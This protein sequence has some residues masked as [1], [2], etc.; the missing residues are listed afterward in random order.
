MRTAR[1]I[2]GWIPSTPEVRGADVLD[3]LKRHAAVAI[4][5][6]APWNGA[7]PLLDRS[8]Q[9]IAER[10]K[11]R[12][13]FYYCNVDLAENHELCQQCGLANVPTLA[14]WVSGDL[15]RLIVGCRES[16]QLAVEIESQLA[17]QSKPWWNFYSR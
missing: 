11:D 3:R 2:A 16:D 5:F 15:R 7:D 6:W 17:P 1:P 12:V 10:F 14:N 8:L 13:V 9:A 4:Y